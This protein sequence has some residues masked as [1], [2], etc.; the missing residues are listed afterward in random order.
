[1]TTTMSGSPHGPVLLLEATGLTVTSGTVTALDGL[2]L[3]ELDGLDCA[4]PDCQVSLVCE[5]TDHAIRSVA[6]R[7]RTQGL[8]PLHGRPERHCQPAHH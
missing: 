3:T 2:D 6:R 8:R 5:D 7:S 1:M 4:Y